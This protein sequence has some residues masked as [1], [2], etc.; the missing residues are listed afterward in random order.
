MNTSTQ[1]NEKCKHKASCYNTKDYHS[2]VV[3]KRQKTNPSSS[4]KTVTS[5]S[6]S[7]ITS[8][9]VVNSQ[10]KEPSIQLKTEDCF[11]VPQ[12]KNGFNLL[13]LHCSFYSIKTNAN[14]VGLIK[15]NILNNNIVKWTIQSKI[16]SHR[17]RTFL[18]T[19]ETNRT[20]GSRT[21]VNEPLNSSIIS[22]NCHCLYV[23]DFILLN[24]G[25][26]TKVLIPEKAT[27][28][29]VHTFNSKFLSKSDTQ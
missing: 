7:T 26:C 8:F 19:I 28:K 25:D 20:S 21:L 11:K 6:Q 27:K 9:L 13:S 29:G 12:S 16:A 17:T 10:Q 3:N 14:I 2:N 18:S 4:K 24:V 23:E 1:F 22:R 15:K 5:N